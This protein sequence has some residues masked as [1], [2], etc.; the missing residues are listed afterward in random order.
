MDSPEQT[1][2]YV[3]TWF[4]TEQ[5]LQIS[6]EETDHA[7]KGT[8]ING[9]RYG[10]KKKKKPGEDIWK[11]YK[12]ERITAQIYKELWPVRKKRQPYQ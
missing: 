8:A 5:T 3:E 11:T 12:Q 6:V 4:M 9:N 10:V 2:V 7:L 1:H